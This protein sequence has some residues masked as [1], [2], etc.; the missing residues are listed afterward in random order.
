MKLKKIYFSAVI[1]LTIAILF[2]LSSCSNSNFDFES[3]SLIRSDGWNLA[4]LVA[5]QELG[6]YK[7][8]KTGN[9]VVFVNGKAVVSAVYTDT[10]ND[11][12]TF[13]VGEYPYSSSN[14]VLIV[15]GT[16]YHYTINEEEIIFEESFFGYTNWEWK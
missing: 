11:M 14:N 8:V 16:E 2:G 4:S 6:S 12:E 5:A 3:H 9:T 15:D 10:N 1:L 7:K 13:T